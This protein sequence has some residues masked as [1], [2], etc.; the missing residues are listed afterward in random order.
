M[1]LKAYIKF[2]KHLF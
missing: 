1:D 2:I